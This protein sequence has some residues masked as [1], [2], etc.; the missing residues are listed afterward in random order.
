MRYKERPCFVNESITTTGLNTCRA[1]LKKVNGIRYLTRKPLDAD[2]YE[3]LEQ[4]RRE[5]EHFGRQPYRA[6][7]YSSVQYLNDD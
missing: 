4:A 1:F 5:G 6:C 2:K 3:S 7:S